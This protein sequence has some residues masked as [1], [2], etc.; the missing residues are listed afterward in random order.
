MRFPLNFSTYIEA[1][2]FVVH[3][4]NAASSLGVMNGFLSTFKSAVHWDSNIH[5]SYFLITQPYAPY[6]PIHRSGINA[7]GTP[8]RSSWLL[9]SLGVMRRW[10][11][12]IYPSTTI[13]SHP[14]V[15]G[16]AVRLKMRQNSASTCIIV[17]EVTMVLLYP[18]VSPFTP[19]VVRKQTLSI[20]E[21][22]H[23][24]KKLKTSISSL[25]VCNDWE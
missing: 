3:Y 20:P 4:Y 8:V 16:A 1:S 15:V 25:L 21:L 17:L 22:G 12:A 19:V 5:C 18:P 23:N 11:V 7:W 14:F 10:R 2:N 9:R 24:S 13:K 6:L